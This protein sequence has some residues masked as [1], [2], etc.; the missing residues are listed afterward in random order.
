MLEE[1]TGDLLLAP[2][3]VIAHG[4]NC[5]GLFGAGVAGQVR[6]RY[7]AAYRAYLAAYR[8]GTLRPGGYGLVPVGA[9]R[10]VAN[11]YTQ[12]RPGQHAEL[13]AI[14]R[15]IVKLSFDLRALGIHTIAIPRLGCGIGGLSWEKEVKPVL[16]EIA[17]QRGDLA[18]RV[19][20]RG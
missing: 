8:Q 1:L 5:R 20:T 3:P 14:E 10:F 12:D 9:G 13:L 19:Y 11:L 17:A 18:L 2:E 7:P 16:S 6:A 15:A 4:C